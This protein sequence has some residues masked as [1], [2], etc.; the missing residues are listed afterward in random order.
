M[1][2]RIRN[3]VQ[4]IGNLGDSVRLSKLS[5]DTY[6]ANA[7]LYIDDAFNDFDDDL[8]RL[9]HLIGWHKIAHSM[10][11]HLIG[12]SRVVVQGRL[13]NRLQVVKGV[14]FYRTE[15]RVSEF[16]ILQKPEIV[17]SAAYSSQITTS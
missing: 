10:H 7:E 6:I 15:V 3:H 9:F 5:D 13:I 16:M 2:Y 4:L 8:G 14:R 17:S 11:Q 12:K 1:P